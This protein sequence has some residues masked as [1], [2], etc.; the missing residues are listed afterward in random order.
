MKPMQCGRSQGSWRSHLSY[1][2]TNPSSWNL[3]PIKSCNAQI[4]P[5]VL[6]IVKFITSLFTLQCFDVSWQGWQA[7]GCRTKM[8]V[9]FACHSLWDSTSAGCQLCCQNEM[10]LLCH[11]V[12]R[13]A[14]TQVQMELQ[15]MRWKEKEWWRKKEG[16]ADGKKISRRTHTPAMENSCIGLC[17][18]EA[19]EGILTFPSLQAAMV[20][21][22]WLEANSSSA[23]W[24]KEEDGEGETDENT[25]EMGI[26]PLQCHHIG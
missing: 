6:G 13:N 20:A 18:P 17:Y 22:F 1:W 21:S 14:C 4:N 2:L 16:M 9:S 7:C 23:G 3:F 26:C 25:R 8:P 15:K 19:E 5:H 11:G 10:T 12:E 24:W